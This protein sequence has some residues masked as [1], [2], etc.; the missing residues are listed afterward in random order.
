MEENTNFVTTAGEVDAAIND[1]ATTTE[2]NGKDKGGDT[3]DTGGMSTEDINAIVQARLNQQKRK[4]EAAH[5]AE[6]ESIKSSQSGTQKNDGAG[7]LPKADGDN[8]VLQALMDKMA[9]IENTLK[10]Q[11]RES[12]VIDFERKMGN[13]TKA[14]KDIASKYGVEASKMNRVLSTLN[15]DESYLDGDKPDRQLIELSIKELKLEEPQWFKGDAN[16]VRRAGATQTNGMP[17]VDVKV[18]TQLA[19]G[20]IFI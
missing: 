2:A 6:I 19:N 8:T 5:R 7:S 9:S 18:G 3:N 20:S 14:A 15:M 12:K 13:L 4:M 10:N 1:V 11:E 17:A 16:A